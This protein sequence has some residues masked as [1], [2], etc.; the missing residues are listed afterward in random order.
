MSLK[1]L[2]KWILIIF[3]LIILFILILL[4]RVFVINKDV[5]PTVAS[6]ESI[7][8]SKNGESSGTGEFVEDFKDGYNS[9][10][11]NNKD[12]STFNFDDRLLMYEGE[13]QGSK[14]SPMFE[15]LIEDADSNL[16]SKPDVMLENQNVITF[17]N[18]QNY[19][20]SLQNA[21][22]SIQDD[23]TYNISFKYSLGVAQEVVITKK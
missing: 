5:N 14:L 10:K 2:G 23:A 11:S 22:N 13:Q 21:K 3:I 8:S 1:E 17:D 15:V 16:Y 18:A 7:N 9:S 19:K 4:F 6:S 12:Y 20:Q